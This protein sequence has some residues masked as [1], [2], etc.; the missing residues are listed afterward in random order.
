MQ[1]VNLKLGLGAL[2]WVGLA[3]MAQAQPAETPP[4]DIGGTYV[5]SVGCAWQRVAI[6]E[7][8]AWAALIGAGGAQ[9]CDLAPSVAVA[10][11]VPDPVTAEVETA[12][13]ATEETAAVAA[14]APSTVQAKPAAGSA[15]VKSKPAVKRPA[16]PRAG[17]YIQV[18]AF[19]DQGNADRAVQLMMS[20]GFGALRQNFTG[21]TSMQIVYAGPFASRVDAEAARRSV[22]TDGY[23][24]AFIWAPS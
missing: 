15:K 3:A 23:R 8:V 11:N 7:Q 22:R 17:Y 14:V 20:H 2:C 5:D 1:S 12:A 6:G 16:F 9:I 19:G 24:D 4:A 21:R 10:P 18:G 13:S